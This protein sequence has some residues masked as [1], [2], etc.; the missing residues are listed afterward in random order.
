VSSAAAAAS[1]T[2]SAVTASLYKYFGDGAGTA[3]MVALTVVVLVLVVVVVYYVVYLLKNRG[4]TQKSLIKSTSHLV[5][6]SETISSLPTTQNDLEY[7]YTLWLYLQGVAGT[8]KHKPIML[9]GATRPFYVFLDKSAN[10]V[11][12]SMPTT[13]SSTNPST[14]DYDKLV[15]SNSGYATSG[16]L[17]AEIDYLPL[18]RWV[19][20]A[21]VVRQ[22]T[23][24]V[25]VNGDIYTVR[26]VADKGAMFS[27]ITGALTVGGPDAPDAFISRL[28]FHNY[29]PLHDQI[30]KDFKRG[31]ASSL[32]LAGYKLRSPI[33]RADEETSKS[34]CSTA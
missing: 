28:I 4:R 18:Q 19:H 16:Y 2:A 27:S 14:I 5:R 13:A 3:L 21:V 20:L 24:T 6:N 32:G 25:F 22:D 8:N 11:Y 23:L 9:R 17:T 1:S 34:T 15:P 7:A 10:R 30:Q 12:V 33:V 31:P 29:A 26:S